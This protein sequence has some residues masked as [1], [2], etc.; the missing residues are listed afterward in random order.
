M[1]EHGPLESF[2]PF[3]CVDCKLCTFHGEYY[4]VKP[5]IWA[6]TGLAEDGG[7][8]CIGDL[9]KRIGRALKKEDFLECPLTESLLKY[10]RRNTPRL[11]DRLSAV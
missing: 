2:M 1:Y 9:E 3:L 10:P 8:L 4:S 7:M 11:N 5:D 6:L